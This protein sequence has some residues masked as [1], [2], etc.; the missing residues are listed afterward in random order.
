MN[1]GI[2]SVPFLFNGRQNH[3]RRLATAALMPVQPLLQAENSKID[4]RRHREDQDDDG[5]D[6]RDLELVGV[7]DETV[8][9]AGSGIAD[10]RRQ[11]ADDRHGD[12]EP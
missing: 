12:A 1:G 3:V 2:R 11:H 7:A 6:R 10:F 8:A 9:Q 4:G 5:I